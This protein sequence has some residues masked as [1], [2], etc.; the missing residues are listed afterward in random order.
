MSDNTSLKTFLI[1]EPRISK[2]TDQ[3]KIGVKDGPA[4][5]VVQKYRA[6]SNSSTS[7]LFNVNIPSINT[8]VDRHLTIECVMTFNATFTVPAPA[9]VGAV[10]ATTIVSAL[11]SAFPMNQSL[12]SASITIN[13]SKLSVQSSDVLNILTKQYHQKYLSQNLQGT[14]NYVDKYFALSSAASEMKRQSGSWWSNCASGEK[15]S[16]TVGRGDSDCSI[17]LFGPGLSVAGEDIMYNDCETVSSGE[18]RR[19]FNYKVKEPIFGLPGCELHENEGC[20][21]GVN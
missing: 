20:F 18:H 9:A 3:L 11:P 6:N 4:S 13:N 1:E 14:P 8:L 19:Q 2:I 10:Q 7:T 21:L 5:C 15:D 12:Q 17:L 16:D